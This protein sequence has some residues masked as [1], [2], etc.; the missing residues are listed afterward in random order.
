MS[1]ESGG[2]FDICGDWQLTTFINSRGKIVRKGHACHRGGNSIDIDAG[3]LTK[4]Q[5]QSLTKTMNQFGGQR[6]PEASIHYQFPGAE[7]C[8]GTGGQ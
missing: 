1:L 4:A 7:T 2:L 6:A 5:I 3:G 8:F